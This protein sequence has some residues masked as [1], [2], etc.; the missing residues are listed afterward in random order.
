MS[1]AEEITD[2]S[3]D[4]DFAEHLLKCFDDPQEYGVHLLFNRWWRH[5]PDATIARYVSELEAMPGFA[6]FVAAR[7]LADPVDLDALKACPEGSLGR[8]YADFLID[9]QLEKNLA[10]N[11]QAYHDM[12]AGDGKLDRMPGDLRYAIIRGFQIHDIQHVL[13]GYE[14]TSLGEIGLQAFCLGQIRFPYFGMWISNVTTR[15][16][17]LHPEMITPI[18]DWVSEGWRYGRTAANLQFERWEDRFDE[19]LSDLRAEFGIRPEGGGPVAH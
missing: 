16:T 4:R 8:G 5:A 11:Y 3:I 9:N 10:V 12:L 14:P 18:M 1:V 13:T 17:Y 19:P 7:H 6:D 2:T 15:M